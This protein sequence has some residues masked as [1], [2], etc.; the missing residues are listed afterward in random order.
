MRIQFLQ[1]AILSPF[2]FVI[3]FA[4]SLTGILL[5]FHIKNGPIIVLHEWSGIAFVVV[6][7]VHLSLN[8]AQ[9]FAYLKA[10]KAWISF[11]LAVVLAIALLLVG[12]NHHGGSH[13]PHAAPQTQR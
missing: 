10:V 2:L 7:M 4:L 8:F 5:F 9:F 13:R 3:F 11:A 1:K 12:L 6:G